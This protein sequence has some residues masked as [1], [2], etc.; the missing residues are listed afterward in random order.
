MT[1]RHVC[2]LPKSKNDFEQRTL[3]PA[4]GL[5]SVVLFGSDACEVVHAQSPVQIYGTLNPMVDRIRVQGAST[6]APLQ[7][8]SMLGIGA[9]A[10]VGSSSVARM[11]SSTS[12]LGFRGTEDLGGGLSAF[13]QLEGGIQVD[14][15][16]N[17]GGDPTR[18]FNRNTGVGLK[19]A[20][21][22]LLL[23]SWDTPYA[24]QHL[25][26]TNGA[27]NPY[28][29]DSSIIFLTPG[30]NVPHSVSSVG[31]ANS[32]ADAAFNRRQ[33]NS[34]Q[35]WS[36][37][38]RGFS[39]RLSYSL[40]EGEKTAANG[41]KYSPAVLGFGGEYASGPMRVRYV[42]QRQNDYFGL[43]WLGAA[44][45]ANPDRPRSTATGS[46]DDVH[47][48]LARYSF[49]PQWA[50]QGVWERQSFRA[51]HVSAGTIERYSRDAWSILGLYRSGLH[52]M[53][54]SVGAAD[55]G[56]CAIRGGAFCRTDDLGA[57][58][59]GVGYRYDFSRRTDVFVALTRLNNR[60]SG[61]YGVFPRSSAGIAPGSRQTALT[62]G[63]EHSF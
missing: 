58:T 20:F 22:A 8:P 4:W 52:T 39:M 24:W 28:A 48:L 17:T 37:V 19:G 25:G 56:N 33:G 61:Q 14:E 35:Y 34:I 5:L 23:G 26:F 11:Q 29:G 38:W 9:Y 41:A 1:Q 53:W 31:R 55:D 18:F 50:I 49:N 47:R 57:S 36:P 7:P 63:L 40:P 42:Y 15:G 16:V 44:A 2:G 30:F 27:R 46:A 12:N 59:V 51:N 43:G 60:R 45:L 10:G 54:A 62:L 13:F 6:P 3:R 32:P 21:G